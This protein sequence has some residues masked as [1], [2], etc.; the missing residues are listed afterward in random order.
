[1]KNLGA[2]TMA[3][4][5]SA[6]SWPIRQPANS[7]DL[8]RKSTHSELLKNSLPLCDLKAGAFSIQALSIDRQESWISWTHKS[9]DYIAFN[10]ANTVIYDAQ[11]TQTVHKSQWLITTLIRWQ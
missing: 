3:H 9:S 10:K 2:D 4:Q 5:S 11:L 6:S 8:W 1:L 7:A